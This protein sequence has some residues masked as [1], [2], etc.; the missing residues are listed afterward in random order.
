MKH[1]YIIAAALL[2][3][4]CVDPSAKH[5]S[6]V[7][8]IGQLNQR[9]EVKTISILSV[10]PA[11]VEVDNTENQKIAQGVGALLGAVAGVALANN[12]NDVG[13]GVLGGLAGAGAGGLA[14]KNKKLVDGVQIIYQE[15]SRTLSSAQVGRPCDF[16]IGTALVIVSESNE[17]RIQ[18]NHDC[19]KGQ[20][21]QLGSV[22]KLGNGVANINAEDQDSLDNLERQRERLVKQRQVQEQ[23]TG[24]TKEK[25][26]SENARESADVE[27]ERE[28]NRAYGY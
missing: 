5:Q 27:L 28:K 4:A 6:N 3:A 7:Y 23:I 17:T 19:V 21:M 26:R 1:T 18:S 13:G 16:A 11:K 10:V 9:Q 15:G 25:Q 12:K 22:S 24:L 20:E 14:V 2:L 8:G